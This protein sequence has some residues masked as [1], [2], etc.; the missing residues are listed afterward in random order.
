MIGVQAIFAQLERRLISERTR[1]ALAAKR[2]HGVRLG[3]PREVSPEV[4][5][6]V[7]AMTDAGLTFA[8]I[9][10]ELLAAGILPSRSEAWSPAS[11]HLIVK[12]T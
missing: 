4:E 6:A 1:A 10:V 7:G 8:A 11:L 2:A 3:R 12:H 9:N 5:A